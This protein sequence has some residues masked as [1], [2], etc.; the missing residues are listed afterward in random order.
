MMDIA[1]K[2]SQPH[3]DSLISEIKRLDLT[4][5]VMELEAYGFTVIPPS[6][7]GIKEEWIARL[8]KAILTTVERRHELDLSD[9]ETRTSEM[10]ALMKTWQ[11]IAEDD[12]FAEAALQP[13]GLAMARWLCGQRVSMVGHTLIAKGPSPADRPWTQTLHNDLH[14]VP[15]G[16]DICHGCNVSILATDYAGVDDGPTILSPGSHHFARAPSAEDMQRPCLPLEGEAGSIAVWNDFT[17]HGALPRKNPGLRLTLVQQFMRP[18][19]RPLQMW[20]ESDL[21]SG[22]I[23]QYPE[24]RKVLGLDNPYPFH[25][26]IEKLGEF[27]WFMEAGTNRF[28]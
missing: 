4:E 28:A 14:G 12:V 19:M 16:G 13:A 26:E 20:R 24:L 23:E 22:Q 21:A 3:V 8:R 27:A 18:Y 7:T 2:G 9:W 11:L 17:W 6:K 5:N 10:P 15:G 25:E 1:S